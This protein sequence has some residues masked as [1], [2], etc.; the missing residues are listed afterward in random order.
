[1][2]NLQF[3]GIAGAKSQVLMWQGFTFCPF[4][5][6]KVKG[7]STAIYDNQLGANDGLCYSIVLCR[8][9][10]GVCN[11]CCCCKY[12]R[13]F[14]GENV[15]ITITKG[16]ECQVVIHS[17]ETIRLQSAGSEFARLLALA[18]LLIA[19]SHNCPPE[20]VWVV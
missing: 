11:C 3:H 2:W 8:N 4:V 18:K 17:I 7:V 14:L 20:E 9:C 13:Q 19:N 16:V 10:W 15:N 6:E 5:L 1:M 12:G